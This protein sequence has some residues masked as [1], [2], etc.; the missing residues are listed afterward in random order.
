MVIE[1]WVGQE[2][3]LSSREHCFFYSD[4][5]DWTA[6]KNHI[7]F[8]CVLC[9]CELIFWM[10]S[11]CDIFFMYIT[12]W[13]K[14]EVRKKV[15]CSVVLQILCFAQ[16]PPNQRVLRWNQ[17]G[18]FETGLNRASSKPDLSFHIYGQKRSNH[19]REKPKLDSPGELCAEKEIH[20]HIY[21][22]LS[23]QSIKWTKQ[24]KLHIIIMGVSSFYALI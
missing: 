10:L 20:H 17:I 24:I 13:D 1:A 22:V 11:K 19:N 3:I 8:V 5:I 2:N 7:F 6:L 18:R 21:S 14:K 9:C 16:V 12:I 15:V 4:E 23:M